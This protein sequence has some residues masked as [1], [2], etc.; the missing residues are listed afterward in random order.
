MTL[1]RKFSL[2][3]VS[4]H[5]IFALVV[6][7]LV[8]DHRVWL[9]AVEAFFIVSFV[10]AS[11]IFRGLFEPLELIASGVEFMK[12][13]DFT[14]RIRELGQP[15]MDRLIG[16]YNLMI[17]NLLAERV[18][19]QEQHFF[20]EKI[21]RV[22]PSAIITLDYEAKV[23]FVNPATEMILQLPAGEFLGK[24]LGELAL[25]IAGALDA[26]A[27]GASAVLTLRG[28]RKVRCYRSQFTDRGHPRT[29]FLIEELTEEFRRTEKA[30]NEKLIRMLSHEVNNSLGAANSLLHSC[31]H[32]KEQIREADRADFE[33]ALTVAI[34]RTEHLNAFMKSFADIVR[35]PLPHRQLTD[36]RPILESLVALL[37]AELARRSIAVAWDIRDAPA[38]PAVADAHQMEQVFLNILKNA[39]EAIGERGT[40]TIRMGRAQ[41]KESVT[42]EDTGSGISE[43]ARKQL[44]APFF[45]TKENGQGIG[46]T[47]VQEILAQ[48]KFEFSLESPP[49]QPTQFTI[50]FS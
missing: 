17:D 23:S 26:L 45:S 47:L 42:I 46:L 48:H 1:R 27:L 11:R 34:A 35:L 32:Y 16:V 21:L 18:R 29:F 41:G 24:R 13:G 36:V 31:L 40:I 19:I 30:A 2:Y 25:P 9:L 7:A 28:T 37:G 39:M 44:F 38:Q 14:S 3:L 6:T 12:G 8:W 33:T 43:E 4:I 10:A 5:L 20:L 49:G 50:F 15:E 22:T